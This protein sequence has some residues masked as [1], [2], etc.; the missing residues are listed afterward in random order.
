MHTNFHTINYYH[1]IIIQYVYLCFVSNDLVKIGESIL[2][3]IEFL[4]KFKLK[5]S[6]E[7]RYILNINNRDI[8]EIK[9][10]QAIKRKYFDKVINW[11]TLFD[12]YAKQINENS[13]LGNYKD[14]IDAYTHNIDSNSNEFNSGNQSALL[15]QI[16]LQRSD[17]LKGKFAL[18]C[19]NYSD[20]LGYFITAAKKKRIVIDGL[21]KKK[22][23]KTY[24]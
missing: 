15:F 17:F 19:M 1:K 6:K 2:D 14:V 21:I 16:N 8:P 11:I 3:Y 10:K 5:T 7:N 9:E 22:S 20:A 18:A 24:S 23:F 12:N 13:A 4:I